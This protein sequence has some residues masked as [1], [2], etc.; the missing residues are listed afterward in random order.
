[1]KSNSTIFASLLLIFSVQITLSIPTSTK[2]VVKG[3]TQTSTEPLA[4]TQKIKKHRSFKPRKVPDNLD[5]DTM[6]L[7][8]LVKMKPGCKDSKVDI[9]LY[10]QYFASHPQIRHI[11]LLDEDHNR[12]TDELMQLSGDGKQER[13][14]KTRLAASIRDL[15]RDAPFA[16]EKHRKMMQESIAGLRQKAYENSRYQSRLKTIGREQL[17]TQRSRKEDEYRKYN[18]GSYYGQRAI[19]LKKLDPSMNRPLSDHIGPDADFLEAVEKANRLGHL[20][21]SNH[22]LTSQLKMYLK[23]K[24]VSDKDFEAAVGLR[25]RFVKLQ[26]K[27]RLNAAKARPSLN[28]HSQSQETSSSVPSQEV[29]LSPQSDQLSHAKKIVSHGQAH[30]KMQEGQGD[31]TISVSESDLMDWNELED[32]LQYDQSLIRRHLS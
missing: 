13:T 7:E 11:N 20:Y 22:A 32:L 21:S 23:E 25:S 14:W 28:V 10:K 1:M 12:V 5:L 16:D 24:K 2:Q 8:D 31:S 27:H 15:L 4:V 9:Q 30:A 18:D 29:S 3:A 19:K 26:S 6:S 17:N